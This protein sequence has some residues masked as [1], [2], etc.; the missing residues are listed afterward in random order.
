MYSIAWYPQTGKVSENFNQIAETA[1]RY[2]IIILNDIRTWFNIFPRMSI[3]LNNS[4]NYNSTMQI[5]NHMIY[6]LRTRKRSIYYDL[7][8]IM[9][10]K[11]VQ[12]P[13]KFLKIIMNFELMQNPMTKKF[14][15][16]SIFPIDAIIIYPPFYINAKNVI[17]F[18]AIK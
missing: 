18:A 12:K 16:I 11:R 1:F 9:F 4:T 10:F 6:G 5:P 3:S 7:K 14:T 15:P 8:I 13:Q 2:Y 17:T